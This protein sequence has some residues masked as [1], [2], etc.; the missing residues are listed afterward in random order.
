LRGLQALNKRRYNIHRTWQHCHCFLTSKILRCYYG[1]TSD[2]QTQRPPKKKKKKNR[3]R[4]TQ[5]KQQTFLFLTAVHSF[6][7]RFSK[8]QHR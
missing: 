8:N 2:S 7:D 3:K 4:S 5:S 1:P 6:H